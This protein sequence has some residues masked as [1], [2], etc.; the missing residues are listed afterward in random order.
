MVLYD[1]AKTSVSPLFPHLAGIR[2]DGVSATSS[3]I[4]FDA[5][6]CCI[7]AA[8]T[9]CGCRSPA[10]RSRYQRKIVDVAVAG[11]EV[12]IQLRVRRFRCPDSRCERKIFSEQVS[13]LVARHQRRSPLVT[14]L[15]TRVGLAL[16]GQA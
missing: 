2:L 16:G 8:C 12:V 5:S 15:L 1:V 11:R 4:Q 10:V 3:R 7:S 13:E 9:R 6:T 14:E